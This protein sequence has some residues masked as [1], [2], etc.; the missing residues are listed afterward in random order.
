MAQLALAGSAAEAGLAASL[1]R[2]V[3]PRGA[4]SGP[5]G[6]ATIVDAPPAPF[7]PPAP[8]PR[9]S[10]TPKE[11][12]DHDKF[13]RAAEFQNRV[14]AEV[15]TLTAKLRRAEPD[16]FVDL[17]YENEG[18]PHVVV[19]FL[20]NARET[21]A[22]YTRNPKFVAATAKYPKKELRAAM[23]FMFRT[24]GEDRVIAGGGIGNKQNRAEIE[25]NV[26]ER[27]FRALAAR[28]GVKIP[29]AVT[30]K[31][32]VEP[33]RPVNRPLDPM[34]AV[35]L[36]SFPRSDRP[37][38]ML[39][40]ITTRAKVVLDDGCFRVRGGPHDHSLVLFPLGAQLFI[41]RAGYLAYGSAEVPGYARVGEEIVFP[42]SMVETEVPQLVG[43][44]R[45]AC[46]SGK[47]V[48][49]NATRS[50]AAERAQAMVSADAES[51]RQLR[52]TYGLSEPR[53]WR[54]LEACRKQMGGSCVM[55]P[56]PPVRR[57]EDCPA[58]S[59]LSY[60]LCRTAEG[61]VRPL[62]QWLERLSG[63]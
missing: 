61:Y 58:G 16:N 27:E 54:A 42:G 62:P 18:D 7:V 5:A 13:R 57:N 17:Y 14:S 37:L 24:F 39:N 60:G 9:R 47:V 2:V 59:S 55:S 19:R 3:Q 4:S 40:D 31:F 23:D 10:L 15:M 38:G 6:F 41:D 12:A 1:T 63:N 8:P 43:P 44:L 26:A 29:D 36:R 22:H 20:R 51:L 25:I 32:A 11:L 28:K 46:G 56:P 30:L 35:M 48:N 52:E 53:A 21:L 50:A 34:I 49:V 33:Y 45:A